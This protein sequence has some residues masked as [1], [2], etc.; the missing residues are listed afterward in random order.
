LNKSLLHLCLSIS[1]VIPPSVFNRFG[2]LGKDIPKAGLRIPLQAYLGL[3]VVVSLVSGLAVL[4][5]TF[6]LLSPPI[7]FTILAGLLGLFS[8]FCAVYVYPRFLIASKARK[9]EA[10]LPLT[11]NFMA[12][13]A[14]A[15]MPPE[16]I[17]RSLANV[18]DEFAIGDE[19]RRIVADVEVLG[20]DLGDALRNGSLRSASPKFGAMLD[21]IVTT[22]HVGGDL[23]AFLRESSEKY[24][25]V[26]IASMKSYLDSLGGVAELYVSFM[27]A[28]PIALVVMLSIM[29]FLGGG[30]L[31]LGNIDPQVLLALLAFVL[32]P[33]GVGILLLLVDSMTPPR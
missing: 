4:V 31:M 13:L 12:V 11:A 5:L 9:I 21:G 30:A 2:R 16:R 23:T 3:M 17:F 25:K 19:A 1:T 24:K 8:G 32:T 7:L 20:H 10:S 18:G 29:S 15:G 33:A 27:I 14:S 26:R 22:T 28:L 6:L